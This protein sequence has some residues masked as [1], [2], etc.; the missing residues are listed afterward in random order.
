LTQAAACSG[1]CGTVSNGCTGTYTCSGCSLGY[2]C[3]N[4]VCT[5]LTWKLLGS[6]GSYGV[7]QCF[8]E[9]D[10]RNC[11]RCTDPIGCGWSP[12]CYKCISPSNQVYHV[13]QTASGYTFYDPNLGYHTVDTDS[14]S[15][16]GGS[17]TTQGSICVPNV[18]NAGS[19]TYSTSCGSA[20]L[21]GCDATY[22]KNCAVYRC[23]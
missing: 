11:H 21:G 14:C 15:T 20:Y 12:E 1:K 2:A 5:A 4:N 13:I 23:A 6:T 19:Y 8:T 16:T 10:Y 17:C 3:N 9:N 22:C 7:T 18:Y